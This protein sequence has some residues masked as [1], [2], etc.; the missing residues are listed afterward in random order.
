[1]RPARILPAAFLALAGLGSTLRADDWPQWRGPNRD[2]VWNERGILETIPAEGLKVRWRVPV[3][4]GFSSP[5]VAQ[6]RVFVLDCELGP[7]ETLKAKERVHCID[8]S[9]GKPLW[10]YSYDVN[11]PSWAWP[12]DCIP[13]QGPTST[14]IVQGGRVYTVGALGHLACLDVLTG[15]PLWLRTLAP[16]YGVVEF[17]I[18]GSPLIEGDLLI[19]QMGY[20]KPRVGVVAFEKETGKEVWKALD[21][22]EGGYC[23][24]P[25]VVEAGGKRQLIVTSERGVTSLDPATGRAWW[26]EKF[27]AG[28][29]TPVVSGNRLLVNGLMF[30]LDAGKPAASVVWP[31]RKPDGQL[32]DT[33]TA[34]FHGDL[35]FSHKKPDRLVCLEASSGRPL[36]ETQQVKSS[37]HSLT[38]CGDGAFLLTDQGELIRVRLGARGYEE[39][40]RAALLKPTCKEA[41]GFMLYAAPAYANRHV[42]ARNDEELICASLCN[43]PDSGR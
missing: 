38:R 22:N 2:G 31:A 41:R 9:T 3:G 24:S 7:K 34:I 35:V 33:T 4:P 17:S 28:I 39:A 37:M 25:L 19:V 32:S 21:E 43:D 36:W 42:F 29:P 18:R 30:T 8:E 13:G 40:G 12:P 5:V 10:T 16:D 6:G 1:M 27:V 23:S 15:T 20:N 11:Y 26:C 14:P